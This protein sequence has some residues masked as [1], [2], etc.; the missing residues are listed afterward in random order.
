MISVETPVPL[1]LV[2]LYSHLHMDL[3]DSNDENEKGQ[4]CCQNSE[5]CCGINIVFWTW[6]AM[7]RKHD[8]RISRVCAG[9]PVRNSSTDQGEVLIITCCAI[10]FAQSGWS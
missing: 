9:D 5:F 4:V 10:D 6:E 7:G 8:A 3:L 1:D 2:L